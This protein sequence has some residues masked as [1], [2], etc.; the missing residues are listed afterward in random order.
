M[1]NLS[2]WEMLL[3][4]AVSIFVLMWMGP[5]IKHTFKQSQQAE[6]R[7]WAGLLLPIGAMVAFVILLIVLARHA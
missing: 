5:G 4:G 6:Q 3:L 7:D 2:I 1:E